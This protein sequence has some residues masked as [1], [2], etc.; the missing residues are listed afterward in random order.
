VIGDVTSEP[1]L[2]IVKR[3]GRRGA[4]TDV[5]IVTQYK[6]ITLGHGRISADRCGVEDA[7]HAVG[8]IAD[9]CVF[10][11]DGVGASRTLTDECVAVSSRVGTVNL[12]QEA[13]TGTTWPR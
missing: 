1:A 6:R 10:A 8:V 12:T 4:H 3:L 2:S 13:G 5:G 9:E 11:F 7:R